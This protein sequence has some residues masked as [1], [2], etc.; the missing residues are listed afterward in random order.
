HLEVDVPPADFRV[1]E[2]QIRARVAA[3]HQEGLK[4]PT[5]LGSLRLRALDG[6]LERA[7]DPTG[8]RE[9]FHRELSRR[10][11]LHRSP[12]ADLSPRQDRACPNA[13]SVPREHPPSGGG[14]PE[15]PRADPSIVAR[16]NPL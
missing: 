12:R 5:Q 6:E 9:R 3:D 2:A 15:M 13:G 10:Q 16:P 8:V 7:L 11:P 1:I 4:K 14:W